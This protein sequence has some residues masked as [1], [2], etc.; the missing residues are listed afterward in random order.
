[1]AS[2]VVFMTLE[3]ETGFVNVVVWPAFAEAQ[4]KALI[5]SRLLAVSGTIQ[6]EDGVLHLIAGRL[7]DLS[8][9]LGDLSTQS[10]DFH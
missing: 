5:K 8:D 6:Q 4:R 7:E 10:R 3:D 1:T 2:G 9:W